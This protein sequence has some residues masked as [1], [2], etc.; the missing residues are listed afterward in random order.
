MYENILKPKVHWMCGL[1]DDYPILP[2]FHLMISHRLPAR[3]PKRIPRDRPLWPWRR[4]TDKRR[5]S[6][7]CRNGGRVKHGWPPVRKKDGG[8]DVL[9]MKPQIL[10]KWALVHFI[11]QFQVLK[12]YCVFFWQSSWASKLGGVCGSRGNHAE[13]DSTTVTIP[14]DEIGVSIIPSSS[15]YETPPR[16]NGLISRGFT[17]R[18]GR[19]VDK[20][21]ITVG[22]SPYVWL[23]QVQ[24]PM[25]FPYAIHMMKRPEQNTGASLVVP[26]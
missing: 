19:A 25:F 15:P 12:L 17:P 3:C 11:I 23:V 2:P 10:R 13:V 1:P 7:S 21:W 9:P 6:R 5:V 24:I 8:G 4:W 14:I 16:N 20:Q 18:I 22:Y 26:G